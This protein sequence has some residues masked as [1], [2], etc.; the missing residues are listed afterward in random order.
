MDSKHT[1][2]FLAR[3]QAA[4]DRLHPSERQ[5]ADA[6][7]NFPGQIASYSA[8]ELAGIAKVSNA[9]VTRFVRKIGYASFDDARQAI[10]AE[11]ISGVALF[12]GSGEEPSNEKL[13]NHIE[14]SRLNVEHS[15][16]SLSEPDLQEL[17]SRMITAPRLWLIGFR[18]GQPFA[19]Y[20]GWQIL[21]V[22]SEVTTLPRD[23]ETL[24]ESLAAIQEE[25]C[26]LLFALRRAPRVLK[27]LPDLL[28]DT[29]AHIALIG[30]VPNLEAMPARWHLP[31]QTSA[32]GPLFNHVGVMA[33]CSLLA[34][35][36]IEQAGAD[37]R[38][39]L[40]AIE[41]LHESLDEL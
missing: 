19:R 8:T 32:A 35:R 20:L 22:K 6:I 36:L 38:I 39:R 17:I 11:Q 28:Q 33:L 31:C 16:R 2:S 30:D 27:T 12:R 5:L 40:R 18:A 26:V 25:D 24:A 21:Q 29:K 13:A 34:S 3:I 37:G 15:L 9:T 4:S 23:G 1:R 7:L 41:D 10:R 14:Q